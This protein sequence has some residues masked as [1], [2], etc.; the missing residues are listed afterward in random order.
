MHMSH[1]VSLGGTS[2]RPDPGGKD[3]CDCNHLSTCFVLCSSTQYIF[4]EE[5]FFNLRYRALSRRRVSYGNIMLWNYGIKKGDGPASFSVQQGEQF[6]VFTPFP[7]FFRFMIMIKIVKRIIFIISSISLFV[8]HFSFINWHTGKG[9]KIGVEAKVEELPAVFHRNNPED[10][11][12]A[13]CP[14]AE[15]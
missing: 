13:G 12:Q 3:F 5:G 14:W 2:C 4:L 15:G 8:L 9:Q 6:K 11:S 1:P 10:P 7:S